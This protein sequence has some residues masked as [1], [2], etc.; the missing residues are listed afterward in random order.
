MRPLQTSH[1]ADSPYAWTRLWVALALVTLGGSGMYARAGVRR[2]LQEEFG[3]ARA[4]ASL[5]FTLPM[6]GFGLGS[7]L[8][9]RL[10]DRFGVIVPVLVGSVSLALG[11]VTAGFS[12]NLL[13]FTA[14]HG[15]LIGVGTS[16]TF[17]PLSAAITPWFPRR[18]GISVAI[19]MS[20]NYLP[21]T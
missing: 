13:Q 14:V 7:V 3:I 2:P 20:G 17:V 10:S 18:L 1:D 5:P 12:Q 4:D 15:L 16:G 21:R 6:I 11:F 8:M 9:G 19:V